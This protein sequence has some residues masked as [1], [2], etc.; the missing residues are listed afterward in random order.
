MDG[1]HFGARWSRRRCPASRDP[2]GTVRLVEEWLRIRCDESH[3]NHF[4]LSHP[5]GVFHGAYGVFWSPQQSA[6]DPTS[7]KHMDG[8]HPP[9]VCGAERYGRRE[10]WRGGHLASARLG[11]AVQMDKDWRSAWSLVSSPESWPPLDHSP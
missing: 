6:T 5:P 11:A 10:G 4:L 8:A 7:V 2:Q 1:W 3:E 9:M